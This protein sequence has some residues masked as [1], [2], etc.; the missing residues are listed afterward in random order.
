MLL[1]FSEFFGA[2]LAEPDNRDCVAIQDCSA[3]S[4]EL[5]RDVAMCC[6]TCDSKCRYT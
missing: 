2:E 3:I 5:E 6:G 1:Q 4:D